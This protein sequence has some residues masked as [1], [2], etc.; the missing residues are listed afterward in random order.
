MISCTCQNLSGYPPTLCMSGCSQDTLKWVSNE[1]MGSKVTPAAVK[2]AE[3]HVEK[4]L[5][6][7][8][9]FPGNGSLPWL[10]AFMHSGADS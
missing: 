10:H 7:Q 1:I 2:G 5:T 6:K 3:Q 4:K 9:S 8:G